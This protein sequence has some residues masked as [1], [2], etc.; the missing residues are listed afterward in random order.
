[1]N[2]PDGI[3]SPRDEDGP[4]FH[5]PWEA[6][7]FAM[8]LALQLVRDGKALGAVSAGNSGAMMAAALFTLKRIEGVDRP[9]RL[10]RLQEVFAHGEHQ[11]VDELAH[12]AA[13]VDVRL[14]GD[15]WAP[16]TV[17]A[18]TSDG[19]RAAMEL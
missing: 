6:Q 14:I 11:R 5:E 8:T 10:D 17:L 9:A 18:A 2:A 1:M 19:Y 3:S 12:R 4:V 16:R 13:G 15:A 7:A